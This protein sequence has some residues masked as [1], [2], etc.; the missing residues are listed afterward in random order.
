MHVSFI[1][2]TDKMDSAGPSLEAA[3]GFLPLAATFF[4]ASGYNKNHIF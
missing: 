2:L 3:A 4:F 1:K